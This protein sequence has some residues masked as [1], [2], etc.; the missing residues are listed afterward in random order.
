MLRGC[1][2]DVFIMS[3]DQPQNVEKTSLFINNYKWCNAD[4]GGCG[5]TIT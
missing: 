5:R 3:V 4:R 2:L 1:H